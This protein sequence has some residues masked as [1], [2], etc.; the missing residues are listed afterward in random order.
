M[1][2]QALGCGASGTDF[3][4]RQVCTSRQLACKV[5][6]VDDLPETQESLG[7][8]E[9]YL[10]SEARRAKMMDKFREFIILKALDHVRLISHPVRWHADNCSAKHYQIGEGDVHLG[11]H[12]SSDLAVSLRLLTCARY[13]FTELCGGG[14]LFSHWMVKQSLS[15]G[16]VACIIQQILKAVAYLH[17]N[18][19]VHRDLKLENVL[20]T[21]FDSTCRVVITDF[22][23]AREEPKPA[24]GSANASRMKTLVGTA[25]YCAP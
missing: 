16:Q 20:M 17:Q 19:I 25:R 15:E 1:S 6:P 8:R 13:I 18:N 7:M 24:G 5:I 2:T 12:V 4:A 11:Q 14:D 3:A 21:G 23:L 22:G 10:T 9:R